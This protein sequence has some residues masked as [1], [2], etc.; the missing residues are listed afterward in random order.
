MK[1]G[2]REMMSGFDPE[3]YAN[4][5]RKAILALLKRK[6]KEKGTVEAPE[7]EGEEGEGP[8]DLVAALQEAMRRE[9]KKKR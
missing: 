1:Q 8:P 4:L 5:R 6:M 9:K 7:V 3:K 2:I